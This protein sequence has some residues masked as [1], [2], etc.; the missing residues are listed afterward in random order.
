[1]E[2]LPDCLL[3]HTQTLSLMIWLWT[4]FVIKRQ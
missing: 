1:M 2:L 3:A 4:A